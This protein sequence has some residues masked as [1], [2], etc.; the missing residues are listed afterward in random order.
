[1]S[2]LTLFLI[3]QLL[4]LISA[5]VLGWAAIRL[6]TEI[7]DRRRLRLLSMSLGDIEALYGEP[8]SIWVR[9]QNWRIFRRYGRPPGDVA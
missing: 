9:F 1:M 5:V 2:L 7:R 6:A 8:P 3:A 4:K